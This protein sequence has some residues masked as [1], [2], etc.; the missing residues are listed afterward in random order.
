MTDFLQ[1]FTLNNGEYRGLLVHLENSYQQAIEHHAYPKP[2]SIFLGEALAAITLL[3]YNL[4]QEGKLALQIESSG[5]LKILIA[6][7]NHL[8]GIR[9]LIQ[10][11]D[12]VPLTT[13][14][15]ESGQC[16]ITLMPKNGQYHQGIVP[17][18]QQNIAASLETYFT[19]SEQITTRMLLACD[20]TR[21]AGL[22]VQQLPSEVTSTPT[23]DQ[24][25]LNFIVDT[26]QA[27]EL[28]TECNEQLLHKLFHEYTTQ[29]FEPEAVCFSCT[30]THEKMMDAV[31]LLGKADALDLIKTHKQVVVTCEFCAHHYGFDKNEVEA[32]FHE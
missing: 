8:R 26:V 20:G 18:S 10:W 7:A 12:D 11:R 28:L 13:T 21:A 23:L 4:K 30:C 6:E 2:M 14:L 24:T 16:A 3:S 15:I 32:I 17:I 29:I 5:P 9:G 25:T 19:Q 1:G 27:K 31:K 22:L